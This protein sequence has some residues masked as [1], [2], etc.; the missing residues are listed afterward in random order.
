[1]IEILSAT[2]LATVQDFGRFGSLGYGVGTSGA[3]DR[4][5]LALGNL[6]LGNPQDAAAIEIPLFPFEVRFLADCAF[7]VTGAAGE[8][9]LDG[10]PLLPF[11]VAQAREGQVLSLGYPVSGSRAY[12][13]L[14]GGV[15]VPLVLGSRSTQLRGEF[16]G[17]HGR[18]LQQGDR[19]AALRPGPS[20]LPTDFGVRSPSL[21]LPLEHDGLPAMRV[22]PAAEYPYFQEQSRA[23]FWAGEWK[24]T[25]QSN[26]YGYRLEGM[27]ILPSAPMEVRSHGIVP[28]VIQVPHGGQPIIQMRDA[29]P[30][31]GYPKFG[32][33]IEADLWRLGQAPIGSRVRFIECSYAEAVAALEDNQRYLEEVR[34]LVELH[35]L[36]SR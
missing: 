5:A 18:A 28:G 17:L 23:A 4:L 2:A 26:R 8:A 36:A 14:A 13:C 21:A 24:I 32:T 27:P 9:T 30:S 16:G 11:W 29:Q 3:M 1:M 19:L 6:L 15:D 31:G 34:R 20:V 22:L 33:V 12:L 7:A 35:G 10:Q 25:T